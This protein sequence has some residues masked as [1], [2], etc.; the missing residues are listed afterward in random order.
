MIHYHGAD[1]HP[2]SA[3]IETVAAG[4]ALL[5]WNHISQPQIDTIIEVCQSFMVDNGAFSAWTKKTPI[6]NWSGYYQWVYECS[7]IPSFDFAVIPD[8]IDGDEDQNDELVN[9]WTHSEW[10][11]APVWHLHESLDRLDRLAHEWP[12]ICLGSSGMYSTPGSELWWDRIDQAMRVI[13]D[14]EGVPCCK[15]HGLRMLNSEIFTKLPLASADSSNVARNIKMDTRWH[16]NY[17]PPDKSSR[18]YLIR[19]RIESNNAPSTMKMRAIQ[20]S[21]CLE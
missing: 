16:G 10:L 5:T 13:C 3:L 19:K 20:D 15:I 7:R 14:S 8:V 1:I 2:Y 12:R 17:S 11:G 4:H 9:E 21:F 18:A 6:T